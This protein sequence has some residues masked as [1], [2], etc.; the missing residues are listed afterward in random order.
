MKKILLETILA[1]TIF[2][3]MSMGLVSAADTKKPI[4]YLWE[5]S[6]G[7]VV[8]TDYVMVRGQATDASGITKLTVNGGIPT[9]KNK[10][11][12]A[13][14]FEKRISLPWKGTFGIVV[15]AIDKYGNRAEKRITVTRK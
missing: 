3:V 14:I 9:I 6:G 5:P 13:P 11:P 8:T 10:D 15:I 7:A 1:I 12:R 4:I 2:L